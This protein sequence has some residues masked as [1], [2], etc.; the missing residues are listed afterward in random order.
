MFNKIKN[1]PRQYFNTLKNTGMHCN[2]TNSNNKY[3]NRVQLT[4]PGG[5]IWFLPKIT[6]CVEI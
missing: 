5:F 1:K 4:K 3:T 2:I 6:A